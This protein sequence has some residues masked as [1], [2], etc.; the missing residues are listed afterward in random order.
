LQSLMV[1]VDPKHDKHIN[2]VLGQ[3]I[4]SDGG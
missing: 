3:W 2:Q 1:E 4:N